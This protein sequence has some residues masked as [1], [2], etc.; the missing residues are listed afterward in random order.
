MPTTVIPLNF[1][2]ILVDMIESFIKLL[3]EKLRST[4]PPHLFYGS[5]L[6]TLVSRSLTVDF[7]LFSLFIFYFTFLFFFF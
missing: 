6:G 7:I 2:N 4:N 3:T 5:H 1:G